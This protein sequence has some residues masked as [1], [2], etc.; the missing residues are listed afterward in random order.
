MLSTDS[1]PP[2]H[3][4]KYGEKKAIKPYF[5]KYFP[6]KYGVWCFEWVRSFELPTNSKHRTKNTILFNFE[7]TTNKEQQHKM[8]I[9]TP[10]TTRRSP[11]KTTSAKNIKKKNLELTLQDSENAFEKQTVCSS[12]EEHF[13]FIQYYKDTLKQLLCM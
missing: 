1:L 9:N 13:V 6:Q 3:I 2:V 5:C 7:N 11:T 4:K 8:N 12:A 10:R